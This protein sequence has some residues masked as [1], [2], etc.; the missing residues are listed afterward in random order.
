[1]DQERCFFTHDLSNLAVSETMQTSTNTALHP[2]LIIQVPKTHGARVQHY[3]SVLLAKQG[4]DDSCYTVNLEHVFCLPLDFVELACNEDKGNEPDVSLVAQTKALATKYYSLFLIISFNRGIGSQVLTYNQLFTLC[5]QLYREAVLSRVIQNAFVVSQAM[6]SFKKL[7]S[8]LSTRFS[9]EKQ[10]CKTL[11][12]RIN[13]FH[14]KIREALTQI[15]LNSQ[16][17]GTVRFVSS[18]FGQDICASSNHETSILLLNVFLDEVG[19]FHY[20]L[21]PLKLSEMTKLIEVKNQA[22][23]QLEND[24]TSSTWPSKA[25]L[26]L[27]E[28]FYRYQLQ[29][30][31]SSCRAARV[32]KSG[33][34]ERPLVCLDVGASPGGW[35]YFLSKCAPAIDF[36]VAVDPG[37]LA[38]PTPANVIHVQKKVEDFPMEATLMADSPLVSTIMSN[39]HFFMIVC[40]MNVS[41]NFLLEKT[42]DRISP[43]KRPQVLIITA[44]KFKGSVDVASDRSVRTVD[45]VKQKMTFDSLVSLITVKLRDVYKY[46]FVDSVHLMSNRKTERTII[47]LYPGEQASCVSST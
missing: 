23:T 21:T 46:K 42:I 9:V 37:K 19:I 22:T 6:A 18:G 15:A 25:R 44:K 35:S 32:N 16:G 10:R 8:I 17:S 39:N 45:S 34:V 30:V 41:L 47:A 28:A 3:L 26:K 13:T 27:E 5:L 33:E 31:V 36:I 1:M 20:D 2:K 40:D 14:R 12:L 29:D 11:Y 7:S 43:N 38:R 24:P 4:I